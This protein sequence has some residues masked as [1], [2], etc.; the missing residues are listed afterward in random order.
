ML[1]GLTELVVLGAGD[2]CHVEAGHLRVPHQLEEGVV[3]LLEVDPREDLPGLG[4]NSI[5][6]LKFQL[7]FHLTFQLIF[8]SIVC[9][10]LAKLN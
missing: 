9:A 2:V 10:V 3:A 7:S 8:A 5:D 1:R 4:V 6:K